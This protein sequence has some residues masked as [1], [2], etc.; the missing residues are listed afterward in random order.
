MVED[1]IVKVL[2]VMAVALLLQFLTT[3]ALRSKPTIDGATGAR[4]FSYG[5]ASKA[6][7]LL[8]L[9]LPAFMGALFVLLY[10][11]AESDDVVVWLIISLIFAAM[12]GYA[13]LECFFAHL[14][15][16]EEGIKSLSPWTGERFFR[17][18]EIESIGYSKLSQWYVL[19]GPHRKKIYASEYLNGF[20]NLTAVFRRNIPSERWKHSHGGSLD[21]SASNNLWRPRS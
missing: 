20:G 21:N 15:V 5:R 1:I 13:L 6:I 2:T 16:S 9:I 18:D 12:S 17:W 10:R 7:A 4:T 19:T 14:I 3:A 11:A 8:S